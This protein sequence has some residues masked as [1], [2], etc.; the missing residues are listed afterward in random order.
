M[1]FR[2]TESLLTQLRAIREK[3]RRE[4]AAK[5]AGN[6][7]PSELPRNFT[8]STLRLPSGDKLPE[9]VADEYVASMGSWEDQVS[10]SH[11]AFLIYS[12]MGPM[13]YLTSDGR[14]LEDSRGWDDTGI[15][16]LTGDAAY[17]ALVTG[18][19]STGIQELL[20]LIP[21]MPPGGRPC[22]R[23]GGTR[24]ARLLGP[25]GRPVEGSGPGYPCASCGSRGWVAPADSPGGDPV[26][27]SSGTTQR[28]ED[29]SGTARLIEMMRQMQERGPQGKP[30]RE[31]FQALLESTVVAIAACRDSDGNRWSAPRGM[32]ASGLPSG[33]GVVFEETE[34]EQG[35]RFITA[36]TSWQKLADFPGTPPGVAVPARQALLAVVRGGFHALVIDPPGPPGF[37]VPNNLAG[38]LLAGELPPDQ[39]G[40]KRLRPG[41]AATP[42]KPGPDDTERM[43]AKIR[44]AFHCGAYPLLLT[45]ILQ[46]SRMAAGTDD[47]AYLLVF[48]AIIGV[49]CTIFGF[50]S[51]A[52]FQE[53][54]RRRPEVLAR[55]RAASHWAVFLLVA[56]YPVALSF[57]FGIFFRV[58]NWFNPAIGG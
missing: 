55:W 35:A 43:P 2:L 42:E 5:K 56:N 45:L 28:S 47:H 12:G 1:P 27:A 49:P 38:S 26:D 9:T 17:A 15:V 22:P 39:G 25:D 31:A 52:A 3:R 37:M 13:L 36:F 21:P 14:V 32:H 20:D 8:D 6:P 4:R 50:M 44:L 53:A 41:G 16:E 30:M 18:A 7:P 29:L 57:A 48:P 24:R 40:G 46:A 58:M 34:N 19:G 10:E 54:N 33:Y 23:C 51:V 11:D